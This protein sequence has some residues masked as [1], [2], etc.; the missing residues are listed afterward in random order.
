VGIGHPGDSRD[1]TNYVL[2]KAPRDEQIEIEAAVDE[3]LRTLPQI[4]DGEMQAAM[5]RL[6]SRK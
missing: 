6:H 3:A 2:G 4:L 1:V 5:N